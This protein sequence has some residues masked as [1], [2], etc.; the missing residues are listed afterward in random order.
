MSKILKNESGI[1]V[2]WVAI[3]MSC[4]LGFAVLALDLGAIQTTRTQLQN[5]AD[6]AVLAAAYELAP[7]GTSLAQRR[8]D[9]TQMAIGIAGL[10]R[11]FIDRTVGPVNISAGDVSFP[12]DTRVTV[13]THRTQAT[14][15]AL[16]T[17]FIQLI[18]PFGDGLADV[19]ADASAEL[20]QGG[21]TNGFFPWVL[22]DRYDDVNGD[23]KWNDAEPFT[24]SNGNGQ[25]DTGEPFD[26]QDKDGVYDPA[27]FYDPV[28]TGY[29][30][31]ADA[32]LLLAVKQGNPSDAL[33]PGFYYPSRF[34]PLG[35][36]T[37]DNP[38]PGASIYKEW[39]INKSPYFVSVGDVLH[40]EKGDM[41][42]P[43]K[44]GCKEIIDVGCPTSYYDTA[45]HQ[46][47]GHSHPESVPCPRIGAIAFF[48]PSDVQGSSD[49]EVT[50]VKISHWFVESVGQPQ[51]TVYGRLLE[52]VDPNA[53]PGPP[54][55][56]FIYLVHLVE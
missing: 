37:G 45:D 54:S 31:P 9:A 35:Y 39:I 40:L 8:Q 50:I 20:M 23:G 17:Y 27:D 56:G 51:N 10:N 14:G 12:N 3:G 1:V 44:Q 18:P 21:G 24:D 19:T 15:D 46:V 29:Q 47:K 38:I 7:D 49:K 36:F 32:G 55:G 33:V 53:I 22:Q 48:D 26:D 25:W 5:A 34:P 52:I 28:L 16:R 42:G 11:A 13:T 4:I 30:T 2:L 6:A 41:Q 43:T